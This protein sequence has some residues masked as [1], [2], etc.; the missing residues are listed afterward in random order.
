MINQKR[1][2]YLLKNSIEINTQNPSGNERALAKF[3]KDFLKNYKI[4]TD[5]IEFSKKR[6]NLLFRLSSKNSKKVLIVMPH[7]DTVPATG[8]W[9]THPL[10]AVIKDDKIYGLGATDCK[11]N[12]AVGI[13]ALIS[14]RKNYE[15]KNLDILFC[16]TADEEKGSHQGLIPLLKNKVLKGDFVLVLDS[17]SFEIIIAQKGLLQIEIEIKGKP[18]HAAFAEKGI[19]AIKKASDFIEKIY[20]HKFTHKSHPLLGFPT[21]NVGTISGGIKPNIVA[22]SCKFSLDIRY[23]PSLDSKKVLKDIKK[24]LSSITKNFK[25]KIL[26]IQKP[27]E[28]DKNNFWIEKFTK[29]LR[30]NNMKPK[31]KGSLGATVMSILNDF[32][33]KSFSFGVGVKSKAH[34]ANEFV[35]KSSLIKGAKILYE[36]FQELDKNI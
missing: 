13:E 26:D 31:L 36:Y 14:L 35:F 6:S 8:N 27:I 10:K 34:S 16:A 20:K 1:L 9:R 22:P 28:I 5:L 21:V 25:I 18:I 11:G 12:L 3:L 32:K 4:K 7:L 15:L 23:L 33:I 17:D 30:N 29:V 19:N 24:I 2:L